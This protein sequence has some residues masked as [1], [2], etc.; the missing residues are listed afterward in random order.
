[1]VLRAD[2]MSAVCRDEKMACPS[3]MTANPGSMHV[4]NRVG[5][6]VG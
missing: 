6:L 4:D 1:M 3:F 5:S 2:R